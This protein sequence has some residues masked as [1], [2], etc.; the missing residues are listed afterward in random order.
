MSPRFSYKLDFIQSGSKI[1]LKSGITR[2]PEIAYR[3]K[4]DTQH[5]LEGRPSRSSTHTTPAKTKRNAQDKCLLRPKRQAWYRNPNRLCRPSFRLRAFPCKQI[6]SPRQ[7]TLGRF[8]GR[9]NTISF[10]NSLRATYMLS[11]S[12]TPRPSEARPVRPVVSPSRVSRPE[13]GQGRRR[14]PGDEKAH[15]SVAPPQYRHPP[16]THDSRATTHKGRE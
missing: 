8:D 3:R 6:L 7:F 12:N 10:S 16:R 1:G 11:S 14:R 9:K 2:G 5:L 15:R 13:P 4:V